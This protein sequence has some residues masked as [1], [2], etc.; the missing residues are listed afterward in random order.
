MNNNKLL[1]IIPG[2]FFITSYHKNLFYRKIPLKVLQLSSF[3]R[4]KK[5]IKSHF[6]DIRFERSL[7]KSLQNKNLNK[8]EFQT[9]FFDVLEKNS[10]QEFQNICIIL[11]S[12]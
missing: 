3:L 1:F 2:F 12:S 6:I 4:E 9:K 8:K 5:G 7:Q 10:I 11:D